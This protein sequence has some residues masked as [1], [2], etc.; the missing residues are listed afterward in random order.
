VHKAIL[1]SDPNFWSARHTVATLE[2]QENKKEEEWKYPPNLPFQIKYGV[3]SLVI[4]VTN[5]LE[6]E[7]KL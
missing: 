3:C 1:E 7:I 2:K 5:L 4:L 6:A